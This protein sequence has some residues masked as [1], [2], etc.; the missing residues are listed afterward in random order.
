MTAINWSVNEVVEISG[1]LFCIESRAASG[2][3]NLRHIRDNRFVSFTD[4]ELATLWSANELIRVIDPNGELNDRHR[5]MLERPYTQLPEAIKK[6]AEWRLPYMQAYVNQR[7]RKRSKKALARLIAEVAAAENHAERPSVRQL[8]RWLDS[9]FQ[10]G[11]PDL[12]DIRCIAPRFHLRGNGKDRFDPDVEDIVLET[13][14]E[15]WL[16]PNKDSG[17]EIL[18]VANKRIDYLDPEGREARFLD[19]DG[20]LRRPSLRTLYRLLNSIDTDVVV[21][22]QRGAIEADRTCEP[23]VRGPQASRPLE[24]VEMDHTLLDVIVLDAERNVPLGRPWITVA[25]DRYTRMIIG[26]YI[27]FMPPGAH[28]VML[29]L[30]NAIRPKEE[31]L[32]RYPSIRNN[33]PCFGKPKAIVVDNGPEFHSRSFKEACLALNIDI[34]YCPVRKPRYKGKI[35]RWFGRLTRQH[36]HKIPG[37]TFSNTKQRG[38]YK[39]EKEAVMTLADLKCS[40]LKWIVDDYSVSIHRGIDCAPVVKWEEGV[41]KSP[42]SM[43]SRQGDLDILLSHVEDRKLTRTGISLHGLLYSAKTKEFKRLINRADKP[44]TVKVRVNAE[45]LNS[46]QVEDWVTGRFIEVPSVDPEYTT[47]LSLAEHA[48]LRQKVKERLKA[49][50]RVT[51]ARLVETRHDFRAD[52]Q[53]LKRAKKLTSKRLIAAIGED[54]DDLLP[55]SESA[56]TAEVT[57]VETSSPTAAGKAPVKAPSTRRRRKASAASQRQAA[58]TTD[59]RPNADDDDDD[60]DDDLSFRTRTAASGIVAEILP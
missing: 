58:P 21:K 57:G 5:N 49:Y 15:M 6:A 48:I 29:C 41:R 8:S 12:R 43:P 13:I 30:R 55:E 7:L 26:V 40:I 20:K 53:M 17:A 52:I 28:T 60:D 34:I 51:V 22:G 4:A 24:Q 10:I 37:T 9:W 27:G 59:A 31:F 33:W 18:A 56:P 50:E 16:K 46:I 25:L 2:E 45:D 36:L 54:R 44:D 47:D 32:E 39:S 11:S 42:V 1:E 35:E 19:R 38:D 3:L 14:E 23:V